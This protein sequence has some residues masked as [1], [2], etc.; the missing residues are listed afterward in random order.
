[1][2]DSLG[3]PGEGGGEMV[4][5]R[6]GALRWQA[7]EP[8]RASAA[9]E[10]AVEEPRFEQR[11][12]EQSLALRL[13]RSEGRANIRGG[14]ED[15]REGPLHR[16]GARLAEEGLRDRRDPRS[17]RVGAFRIALWAPDTEEVA[18]LLR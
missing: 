7:A 4:R 18:D 1:M 2:R 10:L 15:A 16:D 17:E 11:A 6:L 13:Q 12:L 3:V 5:Q 8:R 9:R 14:A